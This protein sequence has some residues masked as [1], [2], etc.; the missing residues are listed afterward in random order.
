MIN[1]RSVKKIEEAKEKE[2]YKEKL[3]RLS[4]ISWSDGEKK[5]VL[6]FPINSDEFHLTVSETRKL[7]LALKKCLGEE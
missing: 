3:G 4:S 7:Y 6:D 2:W 5:V 1:I